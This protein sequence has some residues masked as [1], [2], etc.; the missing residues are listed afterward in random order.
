MNKKP[1][2]VIIAD[3]FLATEPPATTV[4]EPKKRYR[5]K[6]KKDKNA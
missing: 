5:V 6:P 4:I 2:P 1:I 3:D